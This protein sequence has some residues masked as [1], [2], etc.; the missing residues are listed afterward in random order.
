MALH[1][2]YV[3]KIKEQAKRLHSID[4]NQ[5]NRSTAE[6]ERILLCSALIKCA[7]ISNVVRKRELITLL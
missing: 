7:D 3:D 4:L 2:E 6:K 1:N 5:L